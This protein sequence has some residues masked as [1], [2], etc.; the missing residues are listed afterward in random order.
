MA[1]FTHSAR[2]NPP[3]GGVGTA[4]G[5]RLHP[6]AAI[7][8]AAVLLAALYLAG[9]TRMGM[10]STD[11]PRYADIGRAMAQT[12]DWVTPRL[13]GQPWFEK[14]ALLYWMTA[15]GFKLGL[16]ADLAPRLPVALLSLAFLLVFRRRLARVFDPR[17]ANC[18]TALLATSAGWLAYSHVAVTDL[19]LA[20]FF[21]LAVQ[22]SLPARDEAEPPRAAA[23]GALAL[24]VLAKGLPPLVLFLPVLARDYRNWRR[25]FLARPI[26]VFCAVSLP[27]YVLCTLRNGAAFPYVFFVQHQFDRFRTGALQHVQPWW[28][29][30]PVFLLL[31]FPWFPLLAVTYRPAMQDARA[32]TLLAVVAFGF[33]FFSASVN[34]LPGYVLPLVP[35][36][37]ALMGLALARRPR[38]EPWLVASLGLMG[39][40]STAVAVSPRAIDHIRAA[41]IPWPPVFLGLAAAASLGAVLAFRFRARA[42]PAAILLVALGFL[43]LQARLFPVLD[44]AGSARSLWLASHPVC[45]PALPRGMSYSLYYYSGKLLP[46]CGIVDKNAIPSGES[47]R[48]Q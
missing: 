34:K 24:A 45:A 15:T 36:A 38:L 39:A 10:Y 11:E 46:D 37:C 12:G 16:G 28:F 17:A 47:G 1:D 30:V 35:A 14:P 33:V 19:P 2:E 20:A 40:L 13:W 6:R 48:T 42:F 7:G 22:W 32:R 4:S 8:L 43:W 29:Y 23:A 25:W 18:A 3:A 31:L 9:L 41:Q 27:W 44:Q 5:A 26:V 21:T